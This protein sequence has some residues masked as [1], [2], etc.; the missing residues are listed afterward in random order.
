[1]GGI[2]ICVRAFYVSRVGKKRRRKKERR[3]SA[4]SPTS[5]I[6]FTY[7]CVRICETNL[8]SWPYIHFKCTEILKRWCLKEWI[9]CVVG[10]KLS[11]ITS[12]IEDLITNFI[13]STHSFRCHIYCWYDSCHIFIFN[14]YTVSAIIETVTTQNV[15]YL[16][17]FLS[18]HL[19]GHNIMFYL[20]LPSFVLNE[21]I[22]QWLVS[23]SA[24]WSWSEFG[25]IVLALSHNISWPCYDKCLRHFCLFEMPNSLDKLPNSSAWYISANLSFSITSTLCLVGDHRHYYYNRCTMP[26]SCQLGKKLN[27]LEKWLGQ[28]S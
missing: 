21:W 5:W 18:M 14:V 13:L 6:N 24:L 12:R 9:C 7:L 8:F 17:C 28:L 22:L 26:W 11:L 20:Y 15:F 27:L 4:L 3:Q 16:L 19:K 25:M 2:G 10:I 1:M 23:W